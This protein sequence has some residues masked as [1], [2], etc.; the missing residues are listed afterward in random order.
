MVRGYS[1][2]IE[3]KIYTEVYMTLARLN[4]D[5][6]DKIPEKLKQIIISKADT[7]YPYKIDELLTE[8]KAIILLIIEKYL[9]EEK[10]Q[11]EFS[12]FI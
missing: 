7:S 2:D 12:E 10:N 9:K 4:K 5:L 6:I 1:M 11:S 8:S 3:R